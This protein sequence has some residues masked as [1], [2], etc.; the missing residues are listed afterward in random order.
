MSG[1]TK[2][3]PKRAPSAF[4]KIGDHAEMT[5]VITSKNLYALL[6]HPREVGRD[7][8]KSAAPRPLRLVMGDCFIADS[9]E[10][11]WLLSC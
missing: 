1:I 3:G 11:I 7:D 4:E 10:E 5:D 6:L 2:E 8:L 9:T